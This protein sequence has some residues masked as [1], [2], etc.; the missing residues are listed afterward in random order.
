LHIV[1]R[2]SAWLLLAGWEI[3]G[4]SVSRWFRGIEETVSSG[5][6]ANI[7]VSSWRAEKLHTV[8]GRVVDVTPARLRI[9][10]PSETVPDIITIKITEPVD[11]RT[12]EEIR[13]WYIPRHEEPVLHSIARTEAA[14]GA[15]N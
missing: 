9:R 14:D 8:K 2:S 13:V 6:E 5:K 10:Y 3:W 12:G 4:S 7:A 15:G 11:I 1:W